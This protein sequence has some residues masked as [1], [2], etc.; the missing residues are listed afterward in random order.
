M[1]RSPKLGNTYLASMHDEHYYYY[2]YYYYFFFFKYQVKWV[3]R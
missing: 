1:S 3:I 2:Y